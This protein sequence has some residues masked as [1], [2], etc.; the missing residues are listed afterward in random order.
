MLE[1][2]WL[3][4]TFPIAAFL[5]IIVCGRF[6]PLRSKFVASGGWLALFGIGMSRAISLLVAWEVFTGA[7]SPYEDT[8][9]WFEGTTFSFEGGIYLDGLAALMLVVVGI[10]SFLVVMFSIGY[11]AEEGERRIRYYAEICLFVGVMHGLIIANSFLLLFIFWELVGLCSYLLIGF[12]Y[13]KPSAASAAKK[14]F[15]VTRVGDVF[16]LFGLV[17]LFSTFGTLRYSE[18]FADPAVL[19]EH[20]TEL[21]WATLCIFGGAVGKSAQFPLHVW[22]PDAMEGPSTVS[23]LIHAATMVKAGVF[24]VARAYPLIVHSPDTALYIAVTGGFT[25]FIAASMALVMY[26]VKRVLAYSTI[27]QLGYMFLALGTGA[28]AFAHAGGDAY[29]EAHGYTAGMFHLLNH[30]F[31]KALL[32]LGAGAVIHSVHTQDMR[33]MGGLRKAMPFTSTAMGV[34]VLSIA[35]VPFFSGFWSKDEIL[36]AV[37][38][39]GE[40]E[41][42]FAVLW[43]MA[44]ATAG[45]TA[46]YMTRLW[47]MTFTGPKN[48]KA[49]EAPAVMT[50]PLAILGVLAVVSGFAIFIGDGFASYVHYGYH[51]HQDNWVL[52]DHIL[53]ASGTHLSVAAALSGIV[54]A[55]LL[56]YWSP[57][58][59]ERPDRARFILKKYPTAMLHRFLS[60]RLYMAR[61]FDWFG[62]RC[63]DVIAAACNRFD[64]VI[65]DGVVNSLA[66]CSIRTGERIRRLHPGFTGHYAAYSLGG[67]GALVIMLRVVLPLIGW[68]P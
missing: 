14:A 10:V 16:L 67:L 25:A 53:T 33:E 46:F 21:K 56:Y 54:L 22:L 43:M 60:E 26:D 7:H 27:S 35:G 48:D 42:I 51:T 47:M 50:V 28:W 5:L 6:E 65:I 15:L 30:A 49:H 18:L 11:M 64:L 36:A 58:Q 17:I 20:A 37:R 9:T 52:L 68:S 1:Q 23:A 32:F 13:E 59:T 19:A 45:M 34:A 44:L 8:W 12:W 55:S 39:N 2:A 29:A 63:W 62:L 31:F 38:H 41:P 24:L 57:S 4:P 61:L 40:V 3:I 66:D